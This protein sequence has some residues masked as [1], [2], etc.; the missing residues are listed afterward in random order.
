MCNS[1]RGF[2]SRRFHFNHK[3]KGKGEP[4]LGSSVPDYR[5]EHLHIP[6]NK[7]NILIESKKSI[8][9]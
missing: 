8:N 2:R 9:K 4:D 7:Y 6:T 5:H 3:T 1:I